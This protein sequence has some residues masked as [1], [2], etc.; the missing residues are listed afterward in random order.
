MDNLQQ[1]KD[2]IAKEYGYNQF[3]DIPYTILTSQFVRYE[4]YQDIVNKVVKRYHGLMSEDE[5]GDFIHEL[6]RMNGL[7]NN[8]K[9]GHAEELKLSLAEKLDDIMRLPKPKQ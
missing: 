6:K 7:Y 9:Y 8:Q 4:N 5:Y 1:A 2:E 3:T